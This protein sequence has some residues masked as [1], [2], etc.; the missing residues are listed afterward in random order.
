MESQKKYQLI[1]IFQT[2][3][4]KMIL[5][6]FLTLMLLIPL[7]FVKD[8]IYERSQRQEQVIAETNDK[9]GKDVFVYGPIIKVPYNTVQETVTFNDKTKETFKDKKW[10]TNYAYFFPNDLKGN[11]KAKTKLL[12]RSIYESVVFNAKMQFEGNFEI[13]NFSSRN[14]LDENVQWDKATIEIRTTNLQSLKDVVKIN[15]GKNQY[16]FEPIFSDNQKDSLQ[17]L[18]TGYIDLKTIFENQI[19]SFDFNLNYNGSNK[20]LIVP[21][22]KTTT[23]N[24]GSNWGSPSFSGNFLPD[25]KTIKT[26]AE[27][28]DANWKI[29]SINRPF[30]QHFFET[31]PNLADYAFG[32]DFLIPVNQYQQNERAAKYGFLVIGLTFLIFFIIQSMSK[33]RIH[34]FQYFMIGISLIMFYTLLISI[35]EHSSFST[36]YLISGF[37]VVAL[38]TFYSIS[39]LKNKKFPLFIGLCLSV[40]YSFLY[41]IIQLESYALLVGSVGLFAI[42]ALVMYFSRNID[43]ENKLE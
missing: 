14:I 42:L 27:G 1:S 10:T 5:V 8:L 12:N 41:I 22:G 31:L 23:L 6:C 25:H 20:I 30:S 26:T 37:M 39:I 33:I 11:I 9:W 16:L 2:T 24:L 43:W 34:I 38:I 4:A 32:V 18:E 3:T 19:C 28:F 36:A 40:L 17:S 29:L 21:I 15:I 13:P 35:T 7:E